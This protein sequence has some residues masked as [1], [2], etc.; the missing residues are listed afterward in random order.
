MTFAKELDKN[1]KDYLELKRSYDLKELDEEVRKYEKLFDIQSG[2]AI[3]DA[4]TGDVRI[5]SFTEG[6][7]NALRAGGISEADAKKQADLELSALFANSQKTIEV[8]KLMR[9]KAELIDKNYFQDL[10]D[11]QL[12]SE[13]TLADL[14][15]EGTEK[16]LQ[17]IDL[18]YKR[19][20]EKYKDNEA[21]LNQYF[22]KAQ[23]ERQKV[24]LDASNQRLDQR[25]ESRRNFIEN[26]PRRSVS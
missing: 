14:L 18:R 4:G 24:L 22:V 9:L 21:I 25:T 17:E 23:Q 12:E 2:K 20:R 3:K 5:Q 7:I 15:G 26:D 19:Q 13:Q 8:R 6:R 16:Q 1:S 11:L 10:A